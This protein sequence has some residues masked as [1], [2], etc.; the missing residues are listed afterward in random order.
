[1]RAQNIGNSAGQMDTQVPTAERLQT[2]LNHVGA[3][4]MSSAIVYAYS[5]TQL[6]VVLSDAITSGTPTTGDFS[7]ATGGA[8]WIL[9]AVQVTGRLLTLTGPAIGAGKVV[10]VSYTKSAAAGQNIAST[11]GAMQTQ[12]GLIM[13]Y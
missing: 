3:L 6:V 11:G 5:T 13:C 1:M 4:F 9:T 7:V 10:T 8:T 2:A 12:V